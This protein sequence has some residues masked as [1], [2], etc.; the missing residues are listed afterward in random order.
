MIAAP[1]SPNESIIESHCPE[2]EGSGSAL[3]C[4]PATHSTKL[5]EALHTRRKLLRDTVALFGAARPETLQFCPSSFPFGCAQHSRLPTQSHQDESEAPILRIIG[6]IVSAHTLDRQKQHKIML[7]VLAAV[8]P[9]R[10]ALF[11][12]PTLDVRIMSEVTAKAFCRRICCINWE[13][14]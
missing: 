13:E 10:Y 8:K 4:R 11:V 14:D 12:F 7:S 1:R 2:G 9:W 6:R 5:C 3:A